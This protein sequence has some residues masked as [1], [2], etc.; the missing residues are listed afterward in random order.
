[1]G[2]GGGGGGGRG[3][4]GGGAG[5]GFHGRIDPAIARGSTSAAIPAAAAEPAATARILRSAPMWNITQPDAST[6]ASGTP[7]ESA[8]SPA[9]CSQTVGARRSANAAARPAT[10]LAAATTSASSIMD[11][12]DNRRPR[13]SGGVAGSRARPRAFRVAGA[14][15]R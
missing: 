2:G 5:G 12:I 4:G 11:R 6:A 7:T 15:G 3:G 1:L 13:P 8:A 14:R 10:R 9:S